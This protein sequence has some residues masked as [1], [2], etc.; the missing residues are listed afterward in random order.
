MTQTPRG[1]S[2]VMASRIEPPDSLDFFPT[3]PWATRAFCRYV[4]PRVSSLAQ[5]PKA[6]TAWDPCAGEGHM[7]EVL[8]EYFG[9]V[10]ASDVHDYGKGY[11]VG[12][13]V[14]QGLDIARHPGKA[15]W[16][17]FNPPFRLAEEFLERA[18]DEA[19]TGVAALLRTSFIET[20]DRYH[21]YQ[22]H[23]LTLFAPYA[24][25]VP[26]TK[27]IWDPGA[28]TA[29]SYSWFLF[30]KDVDALPPFIIPP[31]SKKALTTMEDIKRFAGTRKPAPLFD[32][33]MAAEPELVS[34]VAALEG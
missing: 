34:A 22:R 17:I 4:L 1:G 7:A 18:I 33:P 28:S 13:F 19:V 3:P 21:F 30:V 31:G 26:M 23:K 5:R 8:K 32:E 25:R 16:I 12:S 10:Y 15:H 6:M 2:S 20:D 9:Q 14:G 24:E 29:T 27:G 11:A